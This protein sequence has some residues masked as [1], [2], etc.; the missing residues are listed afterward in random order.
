MSKKSDVHLLSIT[1]SKGLKKLKIRTKKQILI[2]KI[3]NLNIYNVLSSLALMEELKLDLDKINSIFKKSEPSDGRGK[4]HLIK[5][6][7]KNFK[8]IDES[9]NAN[10]LSVATAIKNFNSIKKQNFKKILVT[11]RYVGV[12]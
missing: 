12:R 9:Y 2:F 8:L 6:Y 3:R 4:I 1:N 7:K 11:W 5:R 10:P